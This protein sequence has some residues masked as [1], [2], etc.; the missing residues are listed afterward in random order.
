MWAE[1]VK[2]A[3]EIKMLCASEVLNKWLDLTELGVKIMPMGVTPT[4]YL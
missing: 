4:S 1:V 3:V 2:W